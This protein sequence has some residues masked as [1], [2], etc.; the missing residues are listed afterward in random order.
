MRCRL[1]AGRRGKT[2]GERM[3]VEQVESRLMAYGHT[4]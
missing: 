1:P 2:K 3:A 4:A